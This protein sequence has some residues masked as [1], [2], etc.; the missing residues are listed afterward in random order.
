MLA[1]GNECLGDKPIPTATLF[2]HTK[3]GTVWYRTP[4]SGVTGVK[5]PV[6]GHGVL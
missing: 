1:G 4:A 3:H 2:G 5:P 6:A